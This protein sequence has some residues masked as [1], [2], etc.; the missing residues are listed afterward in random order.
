MG[1]TE[2]DICTYRELYYE[3]VKPLIR[4]GADC[5]MIDILMQDV[6]AQYGWTKEKFS[7]FQIIDLAQR[8]AEMKKPNIT[9]VAGNQKINNE[10]IEQIPMLRCP[11][12]TEQFK[13]EAEYLEKYGS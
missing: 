6:W 12:R 11:R 4:Q 8:V 9:V 2:V 7:A 1:I 10:Q 13:F 3:H 5:L